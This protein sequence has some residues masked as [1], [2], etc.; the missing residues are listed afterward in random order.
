[1]AN[2]VRAAWRRLGALPA[3]LVVAAFY[4]ILAAALLLRDR[5]TT[6]LALAVLALLA[7]HCLA[8]PRGGGELLAVTLAPTAIDRL[9]HD[10]AG[11]PEGAGLALVPSRC[12]SRR[13]RTARPILPMRPRPGTAPAAGIERARRRS[14][15]RSRCGGGGGAH[16]VADRHRPRA[17]L[18]VGV[19]PALE[20]GGRHLPRAEAGQR[21]DPAAGRALEHRADRIQAL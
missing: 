2:V 17:L 7:L 5:A 4:A 20:R 12:S 1:M 9:L 14:G 10:L 11:A 18:D 6:A 8:R 19:R 21:D 13:S 3:V 16:G 15:R